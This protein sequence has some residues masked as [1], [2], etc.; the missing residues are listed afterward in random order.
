MVP[1]C[2][3]E[4][5]TGLK[6]TQSSSAHSPSVPT[7]A[8]VLFDIYKIALCVLTTK[9]NR[10]FELSEFPLCRAKSSLPTSPQ[11]PTGPSCQCPGSGALRSGQI[12]EETANLTQIWPEILNPEKETIQCH[13]IL[14]PGQSWREKR[15]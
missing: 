1:D 5:R 8:V 14:L 13:R 9:I 12:L 10:V 11:L 15:G 2:S 6:L 3:P 7:L 4:G